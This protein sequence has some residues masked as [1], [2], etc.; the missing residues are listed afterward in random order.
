MPRLPGAMTTTGGD[1]RHRIRVADRLPIVQR[2]RAGDCDVPAAHAGED[3]VAIAKAFGHRSSPIWRGVGGGAG[4]GAPGAGR[5]VVGA[6]V[7]RGVPTPLTS[8]AI[9]CTVGPPE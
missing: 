7:R 8:N 1:A 3:D 6:G 4:F 9:T 2:V 5:A